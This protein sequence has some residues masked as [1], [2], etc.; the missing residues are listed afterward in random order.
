MKENRFRLVAMA[1]CSVVLAAALCGCT[2]GGD[3][4]ID[5]DSRD[6]FAMDTYMTLTAYGDNCSA[7]L[8]AAIAEIER[9]DDMFSVSNAAGELAVINENGG[10]IISDETADIIEASLDLYY[11][12]QGAFDISVYP[13]MVEWGFTTQKYK[14]PG[15][16]V[17][18]TLLENVDAGKIS[19]DAST[20]QLMLADG[21]QIDFGAIAKGY[22]SQRIMD[23]F[24]EYDLKCAI[25]SLGGN[26]QVYG[27]RYD[28]SRWRIAIE[29]PDN[30]D[31]YIGV[32]Q[33]E[34]KAVITSGG[35]ERYFEENGTTYHHIIDPA[36]GYPACSGL[37]SVTIVGDNGMYAD[38]L[39]TALFVMGSGS[40]VKF[41][42]EY[43]DDFDIVLVEEDGGII[44]SEG[45]ADS[46]TSD[47]EYSVVYR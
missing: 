33:V 46:F 4:K 14:V 12:T 24:G 35:Y 30:T 18:E 19:Y 45:I 10:G 6:I 7:A 47:Y 39:S 9:L 41:W 42:Q 28:G 43:G 44:I 2:A 40:A 15:E 26:V 38:G 37:T 11:K 27:K 16:R 1:L 29:N 31:D 20:K 13:L 25:V 8:D 17:I 32:L 5:S 23:I 21:M 3:K 36:T 34:D 22:T